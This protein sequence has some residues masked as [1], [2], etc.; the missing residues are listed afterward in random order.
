MERHKV[1]PGLTGWAQV[2]GWR[3]DTPELWMMEGR[4][5]RDIWYIDHRSIWLDFKIL[6]LTVGSVL[7]PAKGAH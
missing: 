7:F 6:V 1:R 2:Q 3:G 5:I 4:V